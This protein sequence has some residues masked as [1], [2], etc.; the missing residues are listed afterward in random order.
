[1]AIERIN[2]YDSTSTANTNDN[3][4]NYLLENAVPE[5]FDS[6]TKDENN[7][8][9]FGYTY[10]KITLCPPVLAGGQLYIMK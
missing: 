1:M 6:V 7:A 10:G 5:Y 8:Y 2:L 4:Y 9:L 3:L